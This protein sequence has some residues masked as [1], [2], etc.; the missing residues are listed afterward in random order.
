MHSS[1]ITK[2]YATQHFEYNLQVLYNITHI[3][4]RPQQKFSDLVLT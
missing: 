4:L 3:I 1:A 2:K